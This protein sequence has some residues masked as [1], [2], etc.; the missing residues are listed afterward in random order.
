MSRHRG[1][2]AAL[3]F[4]AVT[5]VFSVPVLMFLV[6]LGGTD[7]PGADC[8]P[9]GS[10][11]L[12]A[13]SRR[14]LSEDQLTNAATVVAV[15]NRLGVPRRGLVVA[16]AVAHQESG[17]LNYAND[18]LGGDLSVFQGGIARSLD[19]PHQAVG[20]DHGSLGIFQQ[21]WPW[22]GSMEQLMDP[23]V[24]AQKFYD[25]LL[26]VPHW[27]QL[28]VT[29][30]GQ[31]VQSSAFPDAY[32]DDQVLAERLL[33]DPGF[34]SAAV[35]AAF[36]GSSAAGGTGGCALAPVY[37]GTVAFPLP[38]GSGYRDL[39]NYGGTG[40]RW[41]HGHTGDDLSVACGT[42]VLA[43]TNGT[44]I[45][46]RDQPWAGTWLVQVTTGPGR[47]TTW[48]AHMQTLTVT[49]GER[50]Q[51]GQQLG[52]VGALGNASGC[53]LHFEV[54]PQGG[55]IYQDGIDPATWLSTNVGHDLGG[56]VLAAA[57]TSTGVG[58]SLT[59]LTANVPFTL[60]EARARDQIR[61]LLSRRPDVLVLQEV[62][63][64]DVAAIAASVPGR[65][66][67]WQPPRSQGGSALVWN[68]DELH[69]SQQG[70]ELG[71]RG[72]DYDRWMTW[73]VLESADTQVAVVGLHLPT[74]SS[75]D[76][77][78]RRDFETMTTHYQQLARQIRT[79]GY[80]L[81]MGADWNHPLDRAREPWSP[82]PMLH[83]VGLSTN[84]QAG[85]PCAAS[86]GQ[87]GRID[88][89]AYDPTALAVEDQGCLDRRHSD[90]RPV[91]IRVGAP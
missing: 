34:T 32:A 37:P 3:A 39:H 87:G 15:G 57:S 30:A 56:S 66:E 90:H 86:S 20:S 7:Q 14:L 21:Q 8:A 59:L 73:A 4:A 75:K 85:Q 74:N 55:S 16:L 76:A 71:F 23:R 46:R 67:V 10:V 25:A 31:A 38:A 28:P 54:H 44:V 70:V 47:L 26:K 43:A 45:I 40:A 33:G 36:T 27:Q 5:A 63:S 91:W 80:P 17:F 62:T 52:E 18:G 69:A 9:G 61:W 13:D 12:A 51:A 68:A 89:F 72:R 60:S 22:W 6:V 42:P 49:A 35:S 81:V 79:A 82:V 88:G 58:S 19:L 48:Y 29:V 53:H 77:G 84:W 50:V 64:R 11:V 41:A 1:L 78:M 24:A 83:Q 2:L 65:W